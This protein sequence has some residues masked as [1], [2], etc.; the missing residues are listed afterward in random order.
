[1]LAVVA[2]AG[3]AIALNEAMRRTELSEGLPPGQR[4]R[5]GAPFNLID[6][7]GRRVSD[8]SFAGRKRLMIFAATSDRDRILATLQVL[9]A[10]RDQTGPKAVA[11]ACIW[12][13]T[14]PERDTPAKLAAVLAETGG[15]WTA[16][17][18]STETIRILL[19]GFFVTDANAPP[20]QHAVKGAP[21]PAFS[22]AYLMD[23]NGVFL[24][25]RAISPDPAAIALWLNQSL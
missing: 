11:L 6:Q 13:T 1:M 16:L 21:P 14:D 2:I 18:G 3:A 5:I 9:N 8:T 19:R 4:A 7:N 10:A 22:I 20:P 17:T 23:E 15:D 24:S 12:I 25:H